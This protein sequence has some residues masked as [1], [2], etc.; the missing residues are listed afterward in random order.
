MPQYVNPSEVP[1]DIVAKEKEIAIEQMK[2]SGKPANV[3]EKIAEGKI[4]KFY[5]E[6]CLVKQAYVKDPAKKIEAYTA[7]V[8]KALGAPIAINRFA[9]FVLGET[10]KTEETTN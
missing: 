5:E 3:L 2:A 9:R 6:T 1:A 10:A 4:N 7:E 8:S